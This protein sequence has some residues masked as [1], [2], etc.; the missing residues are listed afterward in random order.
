M[1]HDDRKRELERVL[2]R[3]GLD[4]VVVERRLYERVLGA[5][6]RERNRA[7]AAWGFMLDRGFAT[8]TDERITQQRDRFKAHEALCRDL[9]LPDLPRQTR[10]GGPFSANPDP[11]PDPRDQEELAA[12]QTPDDPLPE[13]SSL[14]MFYTA[15]QVAAR[16]GVTIGTVRRWRDLQLVAR[17]WQRVLCPT[18]AVLLY[19]RIPSV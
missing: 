7:L 1:T 6:M 5:L 13:I 11:R 18:R 19:Q 2:A 17:G 9:G 14:V 8:D 3:E 10:S 12:P 4:V 15:D 16:E